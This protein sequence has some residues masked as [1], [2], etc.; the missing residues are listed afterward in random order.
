MCS[1]DRRLQAR[2]SVARL[3]PGDISGQPKKSG[4]SLDNERDGQAWPND[5]SRQHIT[6]RHDHA[7]PMTPKS[8]TLL[9]NK[10]LA[11]KSGFRMCGHH[12]HVLTMIDYVIDFFPI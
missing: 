10:C 12:L 7:V 2:R 9:T 3:A 1:V 6:I 4:Q 8:R 11:F 5:E